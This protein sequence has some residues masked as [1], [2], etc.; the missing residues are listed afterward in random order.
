VRVSKSSDVHYAHGVC[1]VGVGSTTRPATPDEV[2]RLLQDK[3]RLPT[4]GLPVQEASYAD[5]QEEK[6]ERYIEERLRTATPG[7]SNGRGTQ[8]IAISLG[9]AKRE[10]E[11]VYPTVAGLLFFARN[12]K[13]ARLIEATGRDIREYPIA[14]VREAI[15]NACI[16]RD[17]TIVGREVLVRMFDDRL[18]IESPGGLAGHVTLE[19][20]DR[21]RF[22]RNPQ[23]AV[24]AFEL[25]KAEPAGTGIPRI[26]IDPSAHELK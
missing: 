1:W 20:L 16:H 23:L 10:G 21:T 17:Y 8:E 12:M 25:G 5:L 6:I 18:E 2:T 11:R 7:L 4:D 26:K 14:A 9:L 19:N 22:A 15:A 13:V 24:I 3:G